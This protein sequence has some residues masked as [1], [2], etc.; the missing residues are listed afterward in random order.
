MSQLYKSFVYY[1]RFVWICG[2]KN[3]IS[4][5]VQVPW[6]QC[7]FHPEVHNLKYLVIHIASRERIYSSEGI[8][9]NCNKSRGETPAQRRK[10]WIKKRGYSLHHNKT[11]LF[12]TL[13]EESWEIP[14]SKWSRCR[15]VGHVSCWQMLVAYS[16]RWP[17]FYPNVT[18]LYAPFLFFFFFGW[19]FYFNRLKDYFSSLVA[20]YNWCGVVSII[21]ISFLFFKEN[22]V[23][24]LGTTQ[25]NIAKQY[26]CPVGLKVPWF[27]QV[28]ALFPVTAFGDSIRL[29]NSF[30]IP[31]KREILL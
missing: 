6:K 3:A 11:C 20:F 8:F 18:N 5:S 17:V 22:P 4:W 9:M 7:R 29:Y 27:L 19:R 23:L 2:Y 31:Q 10:S 26:S 15:M 24:P 14:E 21:F 13:A 30:I 1:T 12:T 25:R 16:P 28:T